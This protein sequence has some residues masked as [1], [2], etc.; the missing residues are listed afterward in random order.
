MF[1]V[2]LSVCAWQAFQALSNLQKTQGSN[3]ILEHVNG[4]FVNKVRNFLLQR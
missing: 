1:V 4:A 2:S 3:P